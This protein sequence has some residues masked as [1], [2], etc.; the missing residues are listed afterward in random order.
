MAPNQ[1]STPEANSRRLRWLITLLALTLAFWFGTWLPETTRQLISPIPPSHAPPPAAIP[2]A[3]KQTQNRIWAQNLARGGYLLHFRHAQREKWNDVTAFD[4]YELSMSLA[5]EQQSFHRATCLTEQG[6]E[7]A[8]LIGEL[9]RLA[10][11]KVDQVISSPSCRARQTALLAFG[12]TDVVLNALLHRTAIMPTQHEA[13]ARQL[14]ASLIQLQ[15]RPGTNIVLSGHGGTLDVD[16][17]MVIDINE[18]GGKLDDRQE[19][20]FVVIENRDGQL[21][22]RHV[23]G[24]ISEFAHATLELPLEA[25]RGKP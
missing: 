20:G 22:A 17:T 10:N 13:F 14:R 19:T 15:P 8:K 18:T 2:N 25:R 4:A 12:H 6:K 9:F 1:Q 7:E 11:V 21:I 23:Y 3:I 16:G 5:A 24:T